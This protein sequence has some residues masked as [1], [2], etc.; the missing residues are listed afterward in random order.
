MSG[1][2]EKIEDDEDLGRAV[3]DRKK[4]EN[5]RK[6]KIDP[7]IFR[8]RDGE[9]SLSVDR[10]T[11]ADKAKLT[12]IHEAERDDQ[13]FHGWARV[14]KPDACQMGRL[15]V[16]DK[17]DTNEWHAEIKFPIK[18]GETISRDDQ[19]AHSLNLAKNAVWEDAPLT[20]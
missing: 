14:T 7:K 19:I 10:L 3:F 1:I 20:C 8:G 9:D 13:S 18:V 17:T 6:G 2:A 16:G 15:A 5:A 11:L 12:E 4:A